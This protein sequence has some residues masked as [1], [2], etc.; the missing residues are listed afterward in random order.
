MSKNTFKELVLIVGPTIQKQNTNMRE[1]VSAE[2]RILITLRYLATGCTFTALSLYFQRGERTVG[3]IVEQTTKAIWN[4]LKEPYMSLPNTEKWKQIA[5]RFFELW[6]LPNCLGAIDGKHIRIQKYPNSGSTNFNYKNYHSVVLF[7]CCDAEGLFTTIECGYAGRNS[8]GGI[9]RVS[10]FG[11]WLE[12][13]N[14]LPSLTELPNDESGNKFPYYFAADNAFPLRQNIMRPYPERNI[15]NKMRIFNYRHSRGRKTIE[16]AFGMM[17]Q[18]FQ[19]F[20]TPIRVRKYETIISIIQCACVLHNFIRKKDGTLYAV[21]VIEKNP[22]NPRNF[23]DIENI[24]INETS[25]PQNLRNYLANYFLSP[26]VALPW[27]WNYCL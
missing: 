15:N 27:Q 1:C 24:N 22:Q 16:C 26:N 5:S 4:V 21:P 23:P 7:G 19:I 20:L 12:N 10:T 14:T 18:K 6:Q 25:S 2:E 9:F 17:T 8:D 11:R 13:N 3:S